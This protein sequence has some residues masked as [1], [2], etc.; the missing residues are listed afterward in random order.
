MKI[1]WFRRK[2]SERGEYAG[3]EV[4]VSVFNCERA[5]LQRLAILLTA[6]SDAAKRCLMRAFEECIS[7]STVSRRW[8]LSWTR[9]VVIRN[10]ISL[11]MNPGIES[12]VDTSDHRDDAAIAFSRDDLPGAIAGSESILDLL[13]FD[14]F[15]FV[16]CVLEQ[17]SIYDCALLLGRSLREIVEARQRVGNRVE[18][19]AGLNDISQRLAMG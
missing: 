2:Q 1:D 8:A 15:V 13:E 6:N 9:R 5:G 7:S 19:H 18:Q 3:K 14:R 12:S 10:A 11:V 4:F 16:I 17:Y